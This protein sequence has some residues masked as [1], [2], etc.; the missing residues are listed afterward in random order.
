MLFS[1]RM[2]TLEITVKTLDSQNHKFDVG[3]EVSRTEKLQ[4]FLD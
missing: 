3:D 1:Y 2:T 4:G